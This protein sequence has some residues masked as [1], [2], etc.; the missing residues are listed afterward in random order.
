MGPVS[1]TVETLSL[2]ALHARH[3]SLF[4]GALRVEDLVV[5][6]DP[7]RLIAGIVD[8]VTITNPQV[9][10]GMEGDGLTIGGAPL[11]GSAVS[12]G[13][14][15]MTVFRIDALRI[16]DAHIVIQSSTGPV[17][18]VVSTKLALS[19]AGIGGT[20]LAMDI[21]VPVAGATQAFHVVVP[22][23]AVEPV[24]D[25][26][27]LRFAQ[28]AVQSRDL[29]WA[30]D[31][32]DGTILWGPGRQA[33][34]LTSGHVTS[35]GTPAL[36]T[37][38]ALTGDAAMEGPRIDFTLHGTV[39]PASGRPIIQLDVAGHHD[40]NSGAGTANVTLAPIVFQPGGLRPRDLFPALADALPSVSGS[41]G[42][43]GS[44][45]WTGTTV[46]PGLILRLA[47][48]S[49]DPEGVSLRNMK[50]DIAIAG[51]WPI[52]TRASQ[53][54]TGTIAAGGLP[55]MQTT[56]AFQ[57]LPKPALRVEAIRVKVAGGEIATTPFLVDPARPTID[58]VVSL[59]QVDLEEF[60]T[61]VGVDGLSGS[62]RLDG[63]IPMTATPGT[64]MVRD[65]R[66]TTSGPGVLRLN[67][68]ALPKQ[69]TEAGE[70]MT[71]VLQ[72][73]NDFHYDS[74]SIDLAREA[75][76]DGTILLKLQGKNPNVLDGRTFHINI[77]LQSN[78]DRLI[79]IALRSMEAAQTLLRRTTGSARR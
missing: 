17:E 23:L 70:S 66:L 37:P 48:G 55:P 4:G 8:A 69:I 57:L 30:A 15:P 21:Q 68:T 19:G 53:V 36:I 16:I 18:A 38:V 50:G 59:H 41:I 26:L 64:I 40:R 2:S 67:S 32:I 28:A 14:S 71:L 12:D 78:F 43:S 74:L 58:T 13:A 27:R 31:A 45:A 35:Q 46:S 76:G 73:L 54:L 9:T 47:N 29:P 34:R 11:G 33:V 51:L 63:T 10:I 25:G 60:F 44:V 7:R 49:Y 77:N 22:T 79:D 24:K 56:V 62:G 52:A 20:A 5:S 72:A 3:I 65:G 61:L 39:D 6:Y 75:A 1:L 42:L